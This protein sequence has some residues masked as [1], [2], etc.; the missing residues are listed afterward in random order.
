MRLFK[1]LF[2]EP[3]LTDITRAQVRKF[4]EALQAVPARRS[5]E[6]LSATLTELVEWSTQHP[7]VKCITPATV[8]KIL[9]ALQALGSW[10]YENGVIPDGTLWTNPFAKMLLDTR[11]AEREP[12]T[13]ED[14][15]K[16]FAS[17]VF[18]GGER[19]RGGGGDAAYWLPLLGLYT[20]ARLG[21]LAPL[22]VQDIEI[23]EPTGIASIRFREDEEQGRHL[24]TVS[25]RRLVPIHPKLKS[26]CFLDLVANR[27]ETGGEKARLF[28][29]L[30]QGPKGGYGDNWSKWF[31]RFIRANGITNPASVFHSFRH[32]F[33]DA[34]R[35]AGV[36]EELHDALTGHAGMGGVGRRYGAKDMV[37]RFGLERL[38]EAVALVR[39]PETDMLRPDY[40]RASGSQLDPR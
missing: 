6:L 11:E 29:L 25:S 17:P 32:G 5:G 16:L 23:D 8:N 22:T 26:L 27:R 39:Y 40:M 36:S 7:E 9:T 10:A 1:E 31:G 37:R 13:A 4:R 30:R 34:L 35:S 20:G 28:P 12:W 14:L 15:G 3:P 21:E 19:P 18:A 33:K 24:K 2:G 38:A